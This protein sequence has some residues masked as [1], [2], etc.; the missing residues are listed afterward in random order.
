MLHRTGVRYVEKNVERRTLTVF[1][2]GVQE[3]VLLKI[4]HK[5]V[6]DTALRDRDAV[7][8]MV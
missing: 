6:E 5:V 2:A 1:T 4:L 3:Q 8:R 7:S